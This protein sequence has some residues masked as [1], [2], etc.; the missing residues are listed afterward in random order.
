MKKFVC[1]NWSGLK[2]VSCPS[3]N[4]R[5]V[6]AYKRGERDRERRAECSTKLR[7]G[8]PKMFAKALVRA[9]VKSSDFKK[10]A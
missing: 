6:T 1:A 10:A 4:D 5:D 9:G 7:K 2:I 8:S 3:E